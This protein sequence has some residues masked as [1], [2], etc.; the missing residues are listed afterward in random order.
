[1]VESEKVPQHRERGLPLDA[2]PLPNCMTNPIYICPAG[3]FTANINLSRQKVVNDRTVTID[4]PTHH[5]MEPFGEFLP[6]IVAD[7][8]QQRGH[9]RGN[10]E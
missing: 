10:F 9:G 2:W 3:S 7:S 6:T 1:V 8:F 5:V 4:L